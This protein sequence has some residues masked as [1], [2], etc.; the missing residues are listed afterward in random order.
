MGARAGLLMLDAPSHPYL[1]YR[2]GVP[3]TAAVWRA[4]RLARGPAR[5]PSGV[6]A[7]WPRRVLGSWAADTARAAGDRGD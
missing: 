3:P 1:A 2:P 6:R 4:G 5:G 7:A